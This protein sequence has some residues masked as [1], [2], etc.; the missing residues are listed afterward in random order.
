MTF[1]LGHHFCDTVWNNW[2]IIDEAD[3]RQRKS[4]C[5]YI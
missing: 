2:N 1:L 4:K 3:K 5:S